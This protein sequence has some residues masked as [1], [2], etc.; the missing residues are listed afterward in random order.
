MP[1]GVT[2]GNGLRQLSL[3]LGI[4]L[5]EVIAIGDNLNDLEMLTVAGLG[6]AMG[7]GT[8]EVKEQ[9]NYITTSVDEEGVA[10]VIER[11]IP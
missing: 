8:P 10:R 6:V 11:Y 5:A 9:A 1:A 2:K 7:N 4:E 3:L